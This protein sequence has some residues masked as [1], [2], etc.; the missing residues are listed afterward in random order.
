M[1]REYWGVADETLLQ[2]AGPA[3]VSGI[4][5]RR[6]HFGD[7]AARLAVFLRDYRPA[8]AD[9]PALTLFDSRRCAA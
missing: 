7:A 4:R 1:T 2:P 6:H 3:A 5:R 8:G 9:L